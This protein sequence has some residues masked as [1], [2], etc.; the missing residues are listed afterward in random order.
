MDGGMGKLLLGALAAVSLA[1]GVNRMPQITIDPDPPVA[2]KLAIV[3]YQANTEIT[4]ECTPGGVIK[5]QCDDAG[6]F[7]FV[8]PAGA[9]YLLI[10][11]SSNHGISEGFT[12]S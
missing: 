7:D 3:T 10:M 5:G 1:V 11:D 9:Q 6:H 2:D 8:V 12:V 4:I